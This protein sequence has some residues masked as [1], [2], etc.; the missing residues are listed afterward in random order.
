LFNG[1]I[2][3]AD[4]AVFNPL[5]PHNWLPAGP[6][7]VACGEASQKAARVL[8][9]LGTAASKAM[10]SSAG[11]VEWGQLLCPPENL[12]GGDTLL[13]DYQALARRGIMPRTPASPA[14]VRQKTDDDKDAVRRG[15]RY[16]EQAGL[17]LVAHSQAV[18]VTSGTEVAILRPWLLPLERRSTWLVRQGPLADQIA[19][20][21]VGTVEGSFVP[22]DIWRR[23]PSEPEAPWQS[24][25]GVGSLDSL[26]SSS[27]W[28]SYRFELPPDTRL[29]ISV[30]Y[31]PTL[32]VLG[33]VGFLLAA[34]AVWYLWW[35]LRWRRGR[36]WDRRAR[37]ISAIVLG[38]L[39][40]LTLVVPEDYVPISTGILLGGLVALLAGM[41]WGK[42]PMPATTPETVRPIAAV[43]PAGPPAGLILVALG[44]LLFGG[45]LRAAEPAAKPNDAPPP[46][47][48]VFIPI[49]NRRQPTGE[50]YLVPTE[51]YAE[52][53]R[54]AA[55]VT[56]R[57]KGWLIADATYSGTLAKEAATE[58]YAVEQL[59]LTMDLHVLGRMVRVR[60]PL[61]RE[62][63]NLASDGA[64]LDGRPL[65]VNWE[66][67]GRAITFDV[68]EPGNYRLEM[69][70]Q[71]AHRNGGETTGFELAIPPV[72]TARLEL[73]VPLGDLRI[74]VPSALGEVTWE[75]E[76]R[77]MVAA[78]GPTDRLAVQ[79]GASGRTLE[80]PSAVDLEQLLWLKV[81]PGSV[82]IDAQF[83]LKVIEGRV[84]HLRLIADPRLR[85]LP[86]RE[87]QAPLAEVIQT[88]GQGQ[89]V[90]FQWPQPIPAE[91]SFKATFILSGASGVG[92]LRPPQLEALDIR[93]TRSWLAVSV[94]P[95]LTHRQQNA[96]A[97]RAIP[98]SD[99][100][101]AWGN[102]EERPA[103]AIR[104][105][106]GETSWSL[107]TRPREPQ[108][109]IERQ[110]LTVGFDED[111]TTFLYE[112]QLDTTGGDYHQ[113]RL[114]APPLVEVE[115]VGLEVNGANR[116]ARWAVYKDAKAAHITIFLAEATSGRQNLVIR[117]RWATV[118]QEKFTLPTIAIEGAVAGPTTFQLFRRPAVLATVI[119]AEGI[120]P[121]D[122][123]AGGTAADEL[124]RLVQTLRAEPGRAVQVNVL[125]NH[126]RLQAE[127]LTI[128]QPA[129]EGWVVQVQGHL[130]VGKGVVDEL[131]FEVSDS[132]RGPLKMEPAATIETIA[133]PG[134]LQR[135]IVRPK[136]PIAASEWHFS[137]SG[138][139]PAWA[140]ERISCP[141]ITLRRAN[142]LRHFVAL[143]RQL[144][145]QVITWETSGLRSA[146]LPN[147]WTLPADLGAP[148]IYET[149]EELWKA[150]L[151]PEGATL[152]R[153]QVTIADIGIAW[154]ADGKYQGVACF[155]VDPG[156]DVECPLVLTSALRLLGV[157]VSGVPVL[158]LSTGPNTW[159]IPLSP[160]RLPHRIEV[161]F[162]GETVERKASRHCFQAPMLGELPV[163]QTL[164]TCLGP[165]LYRLTDRGNQA[166]VEGWQAELLRLK[167]LLALLRLGAAANAAREDADRWYQHWLRQWKATRQALERELVPAGRVRSV[168]AARLEVRAIEQEYGQLAERF[169]GTEKQKPSPPQP[170]IIDDT[171]SLLRYTTLYAQQPTSFRLLYPGRA[172]SVLLAYQPPSS[173]EHWWRMLLAAGML[174]AVATAIYASHRERGREI[175]GYLGRLAKRFAVGCGVLA[176][177]VWWLWFWPSILGLGI[178]LMS[179]AAK[180]LSKPK[181]KPLASQ[182]T[183]I[184][185]R[186]MPR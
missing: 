112:A 61:H 159:A 109:T 157:W 108:T 60:L 39:V 181:P 87:P 180:L 174:A 3:P 73:S 186:E 142:S 85:L 175:F 21:A 158:P 166:N 167:N 177:L 59:R 46:P 97:V 99:F 35:H 82:R 38:L 57:A 50:F 161:L 70:L 134:E 80:P 127:L 110:T 160:A 128:L 114:T 18:L 113:L 154:Q 40:A 106:P 81:L 137:L 133:A 116:V 33:V 125:P 58:R 151:K 10:P 169:A 67:D 162:S 170:L 32:R 5:D 122:E 146:Q 54:Q 41:L 62:S 178:V 103:L 7:W 98:P 66:A 13:V 130:R 150:V 14:G 12:L 22:A 90:V 1:L 63:A 173:S 78:L 42:K 165:P 30:I 6:R 8:E 131:H 101:A 138:S 89:M 119:P 55:N 69:V 120:S 56:E 156:H 19:Q 126:P 171:Q 129:A 83:K 72:P 115:H 25:P 27:A 176:G 144:D 102:S 75:S 45:N 77:R 2:R 26:S 29:R 141:R 111:R 132:F 182:S 86:L 152:S 94:D 88:S 93:T 28:N 52:L 15:V 79:W 74:K 51:L 163:A 9:M 104:F 84:R 183:V 47:Y 135:L 49:D 95:M 172:D 184:A 91:T 37:A 179:L 48:R 139:V 20:A 107:S 68:A 124:G 121:L 148:L 145:G 44:S 149:T 4:Y 147:G 136:A 16:L 11:S 36:Q 76:A 71:P 155:H 118:L 185:T 100:L 64:R 164:W 117:G 23:L 17:A 31:L 24:V 105:G 43:V 123:P 168:R 140:G 153:A 143:P 96:D 53:L 34:A 65:Q 92:Q